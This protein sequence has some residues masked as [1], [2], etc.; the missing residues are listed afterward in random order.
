MEG[1][2]DGVVRKII[3]SAPAPV[4]EIT[5]SPKKVT[6][7]LHL[8]V[9]KKAGSRRSYLRFCPD[10]GANRSM[11]PTKTV[12]DLGLEKMI[13]RK[14]NLYSV[15]NASGNKMKVIGPIHLS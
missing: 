11:I 2:K 5:I 4:E 3:D 15:K 9:L 6:P 1:K 7:P 13:D 14:D 10:T 8:Q 12:R